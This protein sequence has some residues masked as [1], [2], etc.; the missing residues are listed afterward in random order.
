MFVFAILV[1]GCKDEPKE[2]SKNPLAG[3]KWTHTVF[4]ATSF[5]PKARLL[6]VE[7]IDNGNLVAYYSN[8][9]T[10]DSESYSAKY[11]LDGQSLTF[12]NWEMPIDRVYKNGQYI[13]GKLVI[14]EINT[15]ANTVTELT[16]IK[17]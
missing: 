6:N 17:R 5:R 3:T 1:G 15:F 2:E 13:N 16:F 8:D 7:F 11:K 14:Y 12:S 4:Q 9:N 10:P